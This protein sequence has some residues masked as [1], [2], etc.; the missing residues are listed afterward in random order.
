MK[1]KVREKVP[2]SGYSLWLSFDSLPFL[3]CGHSM[4]QFPSNNG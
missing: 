3:S 2:W 1:D 4:L